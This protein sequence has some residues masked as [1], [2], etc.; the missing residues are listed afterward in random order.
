ME[1]EI[2]QILLQL[3]S[4]GKLELTLNDNSIRDGIRRCRSDVRD[5]IDYAMQNGGFPKDRVQKM[6]DDQVGGYKEELKNRLDRIVQEKQV[7]KMAL[8]VNEGPVIQT[9]LQHKQFAELLAICQAGL[10]AYLVGPAGSGKTTAAEQVAKALGLSFYFTGAITSEFKLT[11]FIDAQGRVVCPAFRRAYEHG[12]VFLFDEIDASMPQAVLAFNAA[13]ANGMMDFPDKTVPKHKNFYC[14]AA[15][16]TFG[17][18]ADRVYVGRNQMD[19]AT[20][21]RFAFLDWGYDEAL[22]KV[23]T[24]H[25]EWVTY[26]QNVRRAVAEHKIRHVVSPRASMSGSR[27]LKNKMDRKQ[28]EDITLWKGLDQETIKKIK[29]SVAQYQPKPK[30]VLEPEFRGYDEG[31]EKEY[32]MIQGIKHFRLPAGTKVKKGDCFIQ[33]DPIPDFCVR[34][35]TKTTS[36]DNVYRSAETEY[37]KQNR[38]D[39]AI[40]KTTFD[41]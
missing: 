36:I 18:G 6:M 13:I 12:G 9:G 8:Q 4:D 7:L 39:L 31:Y 35:G 26:V 30:P 16:N 22:E 41:F 10:N 37:E 19:G 34:E 29:A 21:D 24:D 1:Q 11:G 25:N 38:I 32:T 5:Q 2:K 33:G 40:K 28:V 17:N 27:L 23:L 15:A 20:I 3:L 14:I